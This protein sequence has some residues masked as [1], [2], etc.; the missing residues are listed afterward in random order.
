MLLQLIV[1]YA[2]ME[3]L[4]IVDIAPYGDGVRG[5]WTVWKLL[6]EK[7]KKLNYKRIHCL[8]QNLFLFFPNLF[9][10]KMLGMVTGKS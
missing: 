5:I 6:L 8:F 1:N 10:F 7:E 2:S 4:I 9:L 3:A